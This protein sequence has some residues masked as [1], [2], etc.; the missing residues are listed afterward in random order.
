MKL[1]FDA[2]FWERTNIL[3]RACLI[4]G[5]FFMDL[6]MQLAGLEVKPKEKK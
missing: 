1:T 2:K 6:G 3:S 5:A 4:I